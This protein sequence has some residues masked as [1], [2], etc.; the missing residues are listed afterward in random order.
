MDGHALDAALYKG[1]E[2]AVRASTS[3]ATLTRN[4]SL[5]RTVVV[6]V[7]FVGGRGWALI[8]FNAVWGAGLNGCDPDKVLPTI[9]AASGPE[10]IPDLSTW[11]LSRADDCHIAA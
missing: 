1:E 6:D 2:E 5:P 7:G 3:V 8:E 9:V 4:M 11:H 10:S